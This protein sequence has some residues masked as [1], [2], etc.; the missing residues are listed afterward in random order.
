MNKILIFGDSIV[1]GR[2]VKK[3]QSWPSL[4]V[5]YFDQYDN[6][7]SLVFNLG[8]PGETSTSL[9]DRF[10]QECLARISQQD[11]SSIIVIS[12]GLNDAKAINQPRNFQTKLTTF[13]KNLSG[14]VD[15]AQKYTKNII[16]IGCTKVDEKQ[17]MIE[18][19]FFLNRNVRIF[20]K[21]IKKICFKRKLQYVPIFEEW[22]KIEYRSLLDKDGI[23]PNEK[24]HKRIYN[25]FILNAQINI[26]IPFLI[27]KNQLSLSHQDISAIRDNFIE[28]K[29]FEND[30]FM[31]QFNNQKT[32]AIVGAPC[33]RNDI[34]DISLNTF[35][36][37]FLPLKLSS[38]YKIPAIIFLGIQEEILQKP[39]LIKEYQRL[40]QKLSLSIKNMADE[41]K[42]VDC[43][44][45][46]TSL[47]ENDAT[48][49][50]ITKE[51]NVNLRVDES[52]NLYNLSIKPRQNY[53]HPPL[54]IAVNKRIVTCNTTYAIRKL[55]KKDY[56]FLIVEDIEQYKCTRFASKL[57]RLKP[58]NF[59]AFLPLPNI[60]GTKTMF[61]SEKDERLLLMQ[62]NDYYA[63]LFKKIK[64]E[65]LT[66]YA[67]LFSIVENQEKIEYKD[68]PNFLKAIHKISK[69]F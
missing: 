48:I 7:N 19:I 68:Y 18:R 20:N 59:L 27:L 47:P 29:F 43:K 13:E 5:H 9:L 56:S 24:G 34:Q 64:P 17:V 33:I 26:F 11:D 23:H 36:Q 1:F 42:I 67:K 2:G 10:D 66:V 51:L 39:K 32:Q 14:L 44:I 21:T 53:T 65:I 16:F 69:Y 55:S 40:S 62:Q 63:K 61:K 4:L 41:L 8:I 15:L 50:K 38:L 49:M 57:D 28:N 45:I 46:D 60:Y 31:G 30:L 3:N 37:I 58:P 12:I 22:S 35:Y 25:N 54:R 6:K 52:S